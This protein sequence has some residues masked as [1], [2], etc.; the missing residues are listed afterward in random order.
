MQHPT[1]TASSSIGHHGWLPFALLAL[2]AGPLQGCDSD[3]SCPCATDAG[4]ITPAPDAA[5]T[6]AP[7]TAP[8][9]DPDAGTPTGFST[10]SYK[11]TPMGLY[12]PPGATKPLPVVMYLHGCHNDPVYPTYWLIAAANAVEPVAVFLPTAPPEIPPPGGYECAD[13]GGTYDPALRPNMKNALAELD[14][15]IAA[16]GFDPTRQ[17]LYGESM[18]GEGVFRLLADFPTR[19]AGAVDAAGYTVD[20]GAA[21]M[22]QTPLWIF[23]G[24]ADSISPLESNQTIYQSILAAGGTQ[25]KLTV[26]PD[27]EHVPGIEKARL[28]PGL[29]DWLLSQRRL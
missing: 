12:V 9:V 27:L 14:R 28:E 18:G 19:F 25:V 26:Y 6:V 11:G 3:C 5:T 1:T 20:K 29:F 13:W 10:W 4:A 16:Y 7:D 23:H 24:G 8:T 2:A 17:Y 15:L 22:A 21:Q